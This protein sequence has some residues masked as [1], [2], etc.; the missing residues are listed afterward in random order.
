MNGS[1]RVRR[2]KPSGLRATGSRA[3]QTEWATRPCSGGCP[4][5]PSAPPAVAEREKSDRGP[6]FDEIFEMAVAVPDVSEGGYLIAHDDLNADCGGA[7]RDLIPPPWRLRI[8]HRPKA[9]ARLTR[10]VRLVRR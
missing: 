10:A 8:S 9:R 3:G 1:V 6:G 2:R 4:K 7:A 5:K